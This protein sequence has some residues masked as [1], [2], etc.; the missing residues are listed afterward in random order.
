MFDLFSIP[1]DAAS[2]GHDK[3]LGVIKPEAIEYMLMPAGD[4]IHRYCVLRNMTVAI[5]YWPN[6]DAVNV[7]IETWRRPS[8]AIHFQ[9]IV[10]IPKARDTL[11]DI[12]N[13]MILDVLPS[14]NLER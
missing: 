13:G 8:A 2:K 6:I 4:G 7:T 1:H 9:T 10:P 5:A 11:E 12:L 3:N 14:D